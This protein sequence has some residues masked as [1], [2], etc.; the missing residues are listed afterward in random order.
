[1]QTACNQEGW[2][3]V[4]GEVSSAA[5]LENCWSGIGMPVRCEAGGEVSKLQ[6][7]PEGRGRCWTGISRVSL[8]AFFVFVF[9]F[10]LAL[11]GLGARLVP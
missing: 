10:V 8:G 6:S 3:V 9:V 11:S 7:T 2:F 4:E 1:M 5:L